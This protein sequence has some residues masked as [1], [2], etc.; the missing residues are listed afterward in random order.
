MAFES[1]NLGKKKDTHVLNPDQLSILEQLIEEKPE[2]GAF[3][4]YCRDLELSPQDLNK[5]ILDVGAGDS[6]FM[7]GAEHFGLGKNVVSLDKYDESVEYLTDDQKRRFVVAEAEMM[8]FS[9]DTFELV[10]SRAAMPQSGTYDLEDEHEMQS[11]I[12]KQ[13]AEMWRVLKPGGWLK[14]SNVEFEGKNKR[15]A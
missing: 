4:S 6:G 8:P 7:R 10:V 5:S 12:A 14:C 13:L 9:D 11:I 2:V 3:F 15:R 1:L